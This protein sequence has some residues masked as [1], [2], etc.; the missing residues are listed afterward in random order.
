[1]IEGGGGSETAGIIDAIDVPILVVDAD[2]AIVRFN[3]A[4]RLALHLAPEDIGRRPGSI[5]ALAGIPDIDALCGQVIA[6][7]APLRRDV[8]L[9]DRQF[10]LR[11]VKP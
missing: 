10:L 8:R 7:A 11:A 3:G 4:A 5:D 9:G 1:V 6:A 2:G